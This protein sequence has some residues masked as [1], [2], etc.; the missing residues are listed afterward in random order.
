MAEETPKGRAGGLAQELPTDRL[1]KEAQNLLMA[2]GEKALESVTHLGKNPG[3]GGLKGGL[4]QVKEKVVDTAKEQVKE[5][6]KEKAVDKV[7]SV[8]PGLGG[9]DG[10]GGGKGGK[11]LKVTNIVEQIDVGAP[12]SLTYNLWTE[13]E[14]FP[15]YMKKVEDVRNEGEDDGEDEPGTESEW[16]AQVLWSHRKWQA[17]VVEQVPDKRIIWTSRADKGHVDG[18][19][20]FHELAPDLTRILFV[21]EY[22]PQGFMERTGNLW[23]A[24]GRRVRLEMKH[25]RRHLMREV[26]LNPDEVV[27][28]RGVVH[29]GEIVEDDEREGRGPEE[30]EPEEEEPEEGREEY[31]NEEPEEPEEFEDEEPRDEDEEEYEDEEP[32][33]RGARR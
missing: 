5:Q 22:W 24:Q 6:V 17:E 10:G 28:W 27:G 20:T 33:R 19:I 21:L 15:S 25:F 29:D 2:L 12:L 14:N 11:K 3:T 26:L 7:K 13:W 9:G 23:R 8:I 31:E 30:E 16:K 32:V 4:E 1:L 18:T